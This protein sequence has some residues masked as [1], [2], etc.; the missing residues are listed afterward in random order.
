MVSTERHIHDARLETASAEDIRALQ[1]QRVQTLLAAGMSNPFYRKQW[2]EAGVQP[3]KIKTLEDFAAA[4]PT[5][6]KAA[7][8]NDQREHPP[9]G[10]RGLAAY[11]RAES[12]FISTTSGTS[13]QGQ[14]IHVQSAAEFATSTAIYRYHFTWAGLQPGESTLLAMPITMLGGGRL[15]YHGA[16]SHG[17]SVLPVGNDS[18][19]RKI[20]VGRQF[21]ATSLFGVTSYMGRLGH[22]L[23]EQGAWPEMRALLTGAEG[24]SL[25][26]LH[27]LENLWNARVYDRFGAT[28][29]GTDFMFSCEQGIGTV[30]RPG[31]LHNI[32]SEVL[33]EV[34]DP[35]TGRH[36]ADGE[37]GEMVISS[38]YRLDSPVV[39]YA[40]SDLATYREGSYCPCGR[41][42]R[43]VEIASITRMDDMKKIK[44]VNTWPGAVDT[45]VFEREAVRDY[46]LILSTVDG[47]E[48][49][50][51]K[52]ATVTDLPPNSAVQLCAD[53]EAALRARTG[54]RFDVEIGAAAEFSE[55]DG[56]VRRWVDQ[57][58]Y[59]G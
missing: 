58:E 21:G 24:N 25:P 39:R 16:V 8:V 40:M 26:W 6:N 52:L 9:V 15:E 10:E 56:K 55:G 43:G 7:F 29:I 13:G 44:G 33:V 59:A 14:E 1:M 47:A 45:A 19:D 49:A 42:F 34:I 28:Q 4:V 20:A 37:Q 38:L 2:T 27:N 35:T 50:L 51:I 3:D 48:R 22:A 46:R 31:M 53:V 32:D 57:R 5:S 36:V 23:G 41:Q 30:E 17:L 18:A 54:L 12:L 11:Q